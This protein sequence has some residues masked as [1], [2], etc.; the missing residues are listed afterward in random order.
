[1]TTIM[2]TEIKVL[3]NL[4]ALNLNIS[5]WSARKK[6]NTEDFGGV[7]LPPE[8]L[9][10]LGSKRIAPPE[11]LRIFST[12][13]ARAFNYL[14]RHG[15]RFLGGWAIPE[16][17]AG[18]IIAELSTIRDEFNAQKETFLNGYNECI[19][20]WIDQHASWGNIIA[21]STVGP[22]YVRARMGFVW[23]MYKVAPL[24]QHAD[25]QAVLNAGLSEEVETLGNTL[26]GEVAKTADDIWT[27]VYEGKTEVTHKAL[28]PLKTL[29]A[30]LKGLSFIEPHIAPLTEIIQM[31]FNRMPKKGNIMGTNL[32]VL[33][34][35][36]CMLKHPEEM[37][38]HSQKLIEGY[39]PATVLDAFL[40]TSKPEIVLPDMPQKMPVA[41]LPT[42]I[43]SMGL[44]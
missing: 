13:K 20:D 4:L 21:D 1:M 22:D 12:L 37:L 18:D 40:H 9:A 16:E 39:G 8:D 10:T 26:F 17:K 25:E 31:A 6:L 14:D 27:N 44:W 30:K 35:L 42:A 34:G 5:L 11:K 41:Q 24:M 3:D 32:L 23:Q 38:R 29:Q 15:V 19:Q 43:P 33:Q 36:V 2:P 28:S 7:E